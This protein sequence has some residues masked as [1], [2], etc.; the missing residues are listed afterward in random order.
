MYDMSYA[1]HFT[2]RAIENNDATLDVRER[3]K[4]AIHIIDTS[5]ID[6]SHIIKTSK[7]VGNKDHGRVDRKEYEDFI[8]RRGCHLFEVCMQ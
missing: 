5:L 6:V 3:I 8:Q 7:H 2:L 1:V 4:R